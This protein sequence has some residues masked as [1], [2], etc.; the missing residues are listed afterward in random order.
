MAYTT[1]AEVRASSGFVDTLNLPSSTFTE[2]I[3]EADDMIDNFI[4]DVYAL[5]LASTPKMIAMISRHITIAL[6]YA[7]EYGEESQGS[8]KG[9]KSRMDFA[10][11]LLE[12][13]QSMKIKLRDATTRAEMARST[14]LRPSFRPTEASSESGE[15]DEPRLTM[16]TEY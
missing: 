13:I 10:V 4:G 1:E 5:P 9:W 12:K 6:L 8:D 3:A 16:K 11:D 15:D 14:L 2:Y 7:R